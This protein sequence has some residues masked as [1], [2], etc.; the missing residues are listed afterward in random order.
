MTRWLALA[1]DGTGMAGYLLDGNRLLKRATGPTQEAILGELGDA[2]R[3]LRLGDGPADKLPCAILPKGKTGLPALEQATPPDIIGASVRLWIAGALASRPHWD[4]VV[5]ATQ[6]DVTHWVHVSADEAISVQTVLTPR[7]VAALGGAAEAD[8]ESIADTLSRPERLAAH[9][10]QAEVA[11]NRAAITG[12][13]LGA[14]LAATRPYWL[15][16][17][18]LV[19]ADAPA[20]HPAALAEQGAPVTALDPAELVGPGLAAL[21]SAFGL[22]SG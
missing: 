2:P 19:V 13:L 1:H 16:Q 11:G 8:A 14:E 4:G 7:L 12:H 20:P 5:C 3:I 22:T 18:V 21:A 9:L 17:E 6:G 10:R 15:G